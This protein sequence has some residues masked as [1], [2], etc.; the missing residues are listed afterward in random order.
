MQPTTAEQRRWF[1]AGA[2]AEAAARDEYPA[3]VRELRDVL[4]AFAEL[5]P[6]LDQEGMAIVL[7]RIYAPQALR[8]KHR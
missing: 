8:R 4:E 7:A 2:T 3:P 1:Q 6:D 5:N